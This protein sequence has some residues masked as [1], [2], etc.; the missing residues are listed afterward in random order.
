MTSL[1]YD[2]FQ[3][4]ATKYDIIEL[5]YNY[6]MDDMRAS[7]ALVQ[8]EKLNKDIKKRTQNKECLC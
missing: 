7:L 2:R 5:G 4:H 3:G 8:L 1:S 6:R